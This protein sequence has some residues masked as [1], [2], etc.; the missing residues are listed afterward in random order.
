MVK[1]GVL[2][3]VRTEF[4]D[5][6][7]KCLGIKELKTPQKRTSRDLFLNREYSTSSHG[8]DLTQ[9]SQ[10]P[11]FRHGVNNSLPPVPITSLLNPLH[12]PRQ[13]P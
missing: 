2:F 4:L 12:N 9:E 11:N 1:C 5:V 3:E 10:N 13:P 7:Y 6:I 8:V